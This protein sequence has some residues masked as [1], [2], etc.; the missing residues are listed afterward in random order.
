MNIVCLGECFLHKFYYIFSQLLF[1]NLFDS[2]PSK[3]LYCVIQFSLT[4]FTSYMCVSTVSVVFFQMFDFRSNN[5]PKVS[6]MHYLVEQ[7]HSSKQELLDFPKQMLHVSK[8]S[9]SQSRQ[10]STLMLLY[11]TIMQ[12][13]G[14]AIFKGRLGVSNKS[15]L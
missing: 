4:T 3:Q 14:R 7:I 6:L 9:E 8:A 11:T 1:Q 2:K 13:V 5:R 15:T 10:Y 12:L